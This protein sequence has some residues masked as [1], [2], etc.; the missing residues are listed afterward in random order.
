[1]KLVLIRHGED[2]AKGMNVTGA[3]HVDGLAG[4]G[5]Q[6]YGEP[7]FCETH[8]LRMT[9]GLPGSQ[10]SD[11]WVQCNSFIRLLLAVF[12]NSPLVRS[13]FWNIIYAFDL[14]NYLGIYLGFRPVSG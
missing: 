3:T 5:L 9:T 4:T 11:Q 7:R 2:S 6:Y 10:N 14:T 1:M 13:R 8:V 12:N